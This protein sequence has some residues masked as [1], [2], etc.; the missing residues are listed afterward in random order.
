MNKTITHTREMKACLLI[1]FC[2]AI[3][4]C[5]ANCISSASHSEAKPQQFHSQESCHKAK[6]GWCN[7][8]ENSF[9]FEYNPCSGDGIKDCPAKP[10]RYPNDRTRCNNPD[11]MLLFLVWMIVI[12]GFIASVVICAKADSP[13]TTSV[14]LGH[15]L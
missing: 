15:L 13:Y 1:S 8:T 10:L 11:N 6:Y 2:I 4:V 5:R 14:S 3:M 7:S 12:A 9:C